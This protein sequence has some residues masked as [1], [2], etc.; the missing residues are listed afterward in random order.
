LF[1]KWQPIYAEHGIAT[2]P[3]RL[4]E[5]KKP[6]IKN[7]LKIGK[8]AS[9]ALAERFGEA[10]AFGFA[11]ERSKITVLAVD[12]DDERVLASALDRHGQTPIVIRSG[13]G[14]YHAWY[15]RNGE[16]RHVRPWKDLP[17]DVLGGG[18]IVAPPSV[19]AKGTYEFLQGSLDDL[20]SLPT[21]RNVSDLIKV[22]KP[23]AAIR[24][25]ERNRSWN[26]MGD[27][28]GRNDALFHD[29]GH[30]AH[31]VADFEELLI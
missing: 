27:G 11:C 8:A 7:Y 20:T 10:N 1:S 29:L 28:S 30:K 18:Y 4:G 23:A 31:H 5:V 12:T 22:P 14:H 19:A 21:L 17:I 9:A 13:S 15:K 2:F 6:A 16:R 24:E 26:E 3:V 25:P